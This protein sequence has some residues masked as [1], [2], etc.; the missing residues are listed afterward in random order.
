MAIYTTDGL[1][2]TPLQAAKLF[3]VYGGILADDALV[4]AQSDEEGN[5]IAHGFTEREAQE[6]ARHIPRQIDR[7]MKFLGVEDLW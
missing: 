3:V 4:F 5:V 1:R 6:I 7:V 2:V